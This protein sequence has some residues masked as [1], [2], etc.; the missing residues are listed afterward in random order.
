VHARRA[1]T[2]KQSPDRSRQP[3]KSKDG[4]GERIWYGVNDE[5]DGISQDVARRQRSVVASVGR[6]VECV[7]LA[8]SF[9]RGS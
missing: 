1:V 8:A 6:H 7:S 5:E 3:C 2:S 4:G 9:W